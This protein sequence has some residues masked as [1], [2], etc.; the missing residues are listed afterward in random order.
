MPCV[1]IHR[2][3]DLDSEQNSSLQERVY[4]AIEKVLHKPKTYVMVVISEKETI[5]LAGSS[6]PALFMEV[7]SIGL[8]GN[9]PKDL[10]NE[11][12]NAALE[13]LGIPPTRIYINFSDVPRNLW[14]FNGSTF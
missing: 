1:I 6:D 2:N 4:A 12:C 10:S 9:T 7:K 3:I 5:S 8:P 11:L 13:V 14:G